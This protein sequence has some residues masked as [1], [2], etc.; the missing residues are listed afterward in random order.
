[1]KRP[2]FFFFLALFALRQ[3]AAQQTYR[4]G[5]LPQINL[6]AGG[7]KNYKF[8]LRLESR[9]IFSEGRFDESANGA[10]RYERTDFA[11]LLI[12]KT[13]VR[14]SAGA[15]YLLRLEDGRAIHRLMQQYSGVSR[16]G[17]FRTGHRIAADQTFRPGEAP[18]FRLRYRFSAE[19]PLQGQNVDPGELYAKLNH[20][21]LGILQNAAFD[22]ETRAVGVLGINFNDRNKLEL[23]LDYRANEFLRGPARHQ[24]W[25]YWGWFV[26]V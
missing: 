17:P 6:T 19:L 16:L 8:N 10:Y 23:G 15:G 25:F 14:G 13:G 4:A 2:A 26:G 1:M 21:Y 20:E 9:Q 5:I 7:P 24:F 18:E 11:A 12:R 22:L 3:G